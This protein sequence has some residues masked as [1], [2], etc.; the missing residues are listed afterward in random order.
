MSEINHENSSQVG[1]ENAA[2][3]IIKQQPANK[4]GWL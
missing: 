1:V 4:T 2:N 3:V